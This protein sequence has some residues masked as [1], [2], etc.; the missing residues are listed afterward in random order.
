MLV[1]E[2]LHF[3]YIQIKVKNVL[4]FIERLRSQM[5]TIQI[6]V[7]FK[8]KKREIKECPEFILGWDDQWESIHDFFKYIYEEILSLK[9]D[10]NYLRLDIRYNIYITISTITSVRPSVLLRPSSQKIFFA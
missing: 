7:D 4:G 2:D 6:K 1:Q 5:K 3:K 8:S 10:L 9:Y